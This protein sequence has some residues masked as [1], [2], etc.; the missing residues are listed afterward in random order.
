MSRALI[1]HPVTHY[2]ILEQLGQGGMEIIY[3]TDDSWP[4]SMLTIGQNDA[5]DHV[6]DSP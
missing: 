5:I 4:R 1:G 2:R 6:V 3:L